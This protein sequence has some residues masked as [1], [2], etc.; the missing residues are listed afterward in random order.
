KKLL[1]K[2]YAVSLDSNHLVVR[3]I[4]YLDDKGTLQIGA[5]VSVIDFVSQN[6]AQMKDHQIYFCGSHP[7]ELNGNPIRNLGGGATK[8]HLIS[9]DLL[10]QRSFSNKPPS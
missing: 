7:H 3:D 6:K 1:D 8:V 9:E 2:G 10:V 4:P 5:I